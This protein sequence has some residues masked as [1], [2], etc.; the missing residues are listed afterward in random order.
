M[1]KKM[2]T[3]IMENQMEKKMEN[4]METGIKIFRVYEVGISQNKGYLVGG[5]YNKDYSILGSILGSPI[6]GNYQ[7]GFRMIPRS[8][9][10]FELH[11]ARSLH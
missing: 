8:W 4:E 7:V 6:L 5:P 2:E 1:E 10:G 3:T 11:I 9:D